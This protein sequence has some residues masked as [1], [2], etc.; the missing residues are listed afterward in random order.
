M[1]D[2]WEVMQF[3]IMYLK[4]NFVFLRSI[5]LSVWWL[6]A[7]WLIRHVWYKTYLCLC[8]TYFKQFSFF[9]SLWVFFFFPSIFL[10][11]YGKE[12]NNS[13]SLQ[14]DVRIAQDSTPRFPSQT[15]WHIHLYL[16]FPSFSFPS[17]YFT[18]T[19][20]HAC[21]SSNQLPLNYD[22]FFLSYENTWKSQS[23]ALTEPS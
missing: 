1:E 19:F 9:F 21:L 6:E 8:K 7:C 10:N 4:K 23:T 15:R 20:R 5:V 16:F 18:T 3:Y 17:N 14:V 12:D 11:L 13:L 22:I 2:D